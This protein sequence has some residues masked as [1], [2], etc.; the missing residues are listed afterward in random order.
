MTT[1]QE[2]EWSAPQSARTAFDEAAAYAPDP[3][4]RALCALPDRL[5][6]EAQEIRLRAGAPL[7]LST[8]TGEWM[9]TAEGDA[10][11]AAAKGLVCA[12]A[13]LEECF[14]ALC[15]YSVHT[16]QSEV[17]AGFI[18]TRGG[19]RAGIAGTAVLDGGR[20]V[21]VR[22]I[23]SICLRIARR[24]DGCAS[25]LAVRLTEGGRLRSASICGEPSSG[26]SSLLRDLARQLSGGSRGRRYRT[27]VVDERGEL[28][29][30]R[31]GGLSG[32]D[33]LRFCPKAAGIQQAVRCLAPDV[34]I[35][36]ELG[37]E[38][39]VHA[40]V[41]GLNSGVAAVASAHCRDR[42][43]LLRRP[44]LRAALESGAF[45][46][47][48]FLTGRGAPGALARVEEAGD[49]LAQ[50]GRVVSGVPN[51]SGGGLVRIGRAQPARGF[52]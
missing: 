44:P 22:G 33:V 6:A 40:V 48:V 4:R 28:S 41:E 38:Q 45:D 2:S 27:A 42:D 24:H 1:I 15:E 37:T 49:L 52:L 51:G 47:V 50:G 8:P 21:S 36:D 16:H 9:V 26:K 10:T 20:V 12:P 7:M 23:T 25:A 43:T 34:V 29:G 3:A 32:C 19:C 18:T 39:E 17:S 31:G 13:L 30:E 46:L 11:Q 5:K 14:L 35:F